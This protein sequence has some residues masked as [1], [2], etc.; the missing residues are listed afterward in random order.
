MRRSWVAALNDD[1][2]P[3]LRKDPAGGQGIPLLRTN[4]GDADPQR[5]LPRLMDLHREGR[6]PV[7]PADPTAPLREDQ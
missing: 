6:P 1:A 2:P 3:R 4:Q 7:R 5:F